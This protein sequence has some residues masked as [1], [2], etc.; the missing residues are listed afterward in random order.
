MMNRYG[1]VM[2]TRVLILVVIRMHCVKLIVIALY[3]PR[4]IIGV[5]DTEIALGKL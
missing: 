3:A 2:S 4:I 1:E 5:T